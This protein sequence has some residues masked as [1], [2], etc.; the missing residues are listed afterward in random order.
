M[1][2]DYRYRPIDVGLC[3]LSLAIGSAL[4]IPFQ[5]ASWLSR[6]R[7]RPPRT[8]SMTFQKA[9]VWTSH[10]ARRTL[11]MVFLPLA[12]IGYALSSR[13][14]EV[15]V[16]VPCVFAGLV[17]YCSNL[18]IAE[19]YAQMML[20]FDTS[21]LQ[22]GMTGRPARQSAMGRFR[23]QRTNFSCYPRVSAG[24]A[25]TES[26]KFVFGAVAT[27]IGG[28]VER[29]YGA[30]QSAGI[31]AGVLL[32]LTLFFTAVLFRWKSVQTVPGRRDRPDGGEGGWEPVILGDPSGL[33]R[34]INIL[35]AGEQTR[36]SEIRRRNHLTDRHSR[37]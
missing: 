13:G 37:T 36:W 19:C 18:A 15:P 3:V 6:S 27:G 35:E 33:T 24:I 34:K 1:S 29:R 10:T 25:V 16:A 28:R 30:M 31:V 9:I 4:A 22:P 26:L 12:A 7:Y 5:R 23:G 11:F 8:D 32:G 21:D 17:G 14:S 2:T 20:T